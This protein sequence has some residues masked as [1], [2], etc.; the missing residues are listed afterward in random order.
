[1]RF[2]AAVLL[3][4]PITQLGF[5]HTESVNRSL[6]PQRRVIILSVHSECMTREVGLGLN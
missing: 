2:V 6:N 1:M 5:T 3:F 4:F